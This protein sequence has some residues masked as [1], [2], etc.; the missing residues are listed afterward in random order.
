ML[1]V[2]LIASPSWA[3][4]EPATSGEEADNAGAYGTAPP[5]PPGSSE[6][7]KD[8][9][10]EGAYGNPDP[11]ADT[12]DS[13]QPK[14]KEEIGGLYATLAAGMTFTPGDNHEWGDGQN[15]PSGSIPGTNET[16]SPG[17]SASDPLGGFVE[18]RLGYSFGIIGVEGFAL[19]AADWSTG[20]I[21][22]DQ[23]LLQGTLPDFLTNMQIGRAGGGFG[24]NVRVQSLPGPVRVSGGLGAGGMFR[25]VYSNLSSLEGNSEAYVAPIIRA[26]VGVVLLNLFT[27]G[28]MGWAE[29]SSDVTLTPDLNAV[30]PNPDVADAVETAIGD[31]TVYQG[32]QYFLGFFVGLH[33]GK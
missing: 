21:V 9:F 25:Y 7:T 27:I 10:G 14:E 33:M 12:S 6:A 17:C 29:F 26:D 31:I 16:W 32:T 22:D 11:N 18:F 5:P 3:A 13:L 23:N 4:D 2:S 19:G 20:K 1:L 15:C 24:G 28:A 8:E 30:I